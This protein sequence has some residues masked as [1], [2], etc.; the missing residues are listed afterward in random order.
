MR[1]KLDRGEDEEVRKERKRQRRHRTSRNIFGGH[2]APLAIGSGDRCKRV[3]GSCL[4]SIESK[5]FTEAV[6][7]QRSTDENISNTGYAHSSLVLIL[8]ALLAAVWWRSCVKYSEEKNSQ[9][10][11]IEN[12]PLGL[13]E[14]EKD[15][16]RKKEEEE[17]V[18]EEEN[19]NEF[20]ESTGLGRAHSDLRYRETRQSNLEP[21]TMT[22][23]AQLVLTALN[24]RQKNDTARESHL[25]ISNLTQKY[26]RKAAGS[27]RMLRSPAKR[28]RTK[29]NFRGADTLPARA[30]EIAAKAEC[31]KRV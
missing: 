30:K 4:S 23:T 18:V 15:E 19:G 9:S 27:P 16:K 24:T 26:P 31:N 2:G 29:P 28:P 7:K 13:F 3:P 17:E 12:N 22:N 1:L 11:Q 25:Q 10:I 20:I 21:S 5:H 14:E 6:A 8:L